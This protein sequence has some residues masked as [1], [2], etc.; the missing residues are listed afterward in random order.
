MPS[1]QVGPFAPHSHKQL[2]AI[3]ENY[4]CGK[5]DRL[6]IGASSI[7]MPGMLEH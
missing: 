1:C 6:M 7:K 4:G 2:T 3:N 5:K